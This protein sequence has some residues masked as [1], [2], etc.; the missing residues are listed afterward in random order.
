M[1]FRGYTDSEDWNIR[2]LISMAFDRQCWACGATWREWSLRADYTWY[3]GPIWQ[4]CVGPF[5][6]AIGPWW[7]TPTQF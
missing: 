7:P 2:T 1:R 3:D 5:W 6:V 4:V